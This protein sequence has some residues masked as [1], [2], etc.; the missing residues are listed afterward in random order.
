MM[1][2]GSVSFYHHHKRKIQYSMFRFKISE[3]V[4]RLH[5]M[6]RGLPAFSGDYLATCWFHDPGLLVCGGTD[7]CQSS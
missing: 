2:M 1:A 4:V 3:T 5:A 7:M 6:C